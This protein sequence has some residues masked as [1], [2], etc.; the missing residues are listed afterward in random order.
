MNNCGE[1]LF[2]LDSRAIR[3]DTEHEYKKEWGDRKFLDLNT[4]ETALRHCSDFVEFSQLH[5]ERLAKFDKR[6]CYSRN[7]HSK[8]KKVLVLLN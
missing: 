3:G 1:S 6:R 4:I 8:Y 2:V 5:R 7:C